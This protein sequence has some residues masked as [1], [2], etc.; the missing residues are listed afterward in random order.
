MIIYD[1]PIAHRGLHNKEGVT[2]NSISAFKAAIEK[3]Y[4][5]E[6]DVR[7]L[8]DGAVVAFHDPSLKRVCGKN[9]LIKNL[10]SDDINGKE[11]LLPNGEHIPFLSELLALTEGSKSKILLELKWCSHVN[12]K[13]EEAVYKL[14]KGKEDFIIIQ[15]FRPTTLNWFN[16]HAPEFCR[17]ILSSYTQKPVMAA[18]VKA[19]NA[20][21]YAIAKPYFLAFDVLNFPDK[22]L[23]TKV[24]RKGWKLILWTVRTQKNLETANAVEPDNIIFEYIKPEEFKKYS[25]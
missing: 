19:F 9:V 11:Y 6:T 21:G 16:K 24:K 17:G 25:S 3:E 1:R 20:F 2:E 4:H 18:I 5:I 22:K 23:M 14:I 10:T 8:K 7:L 15:S 13:L 12:H